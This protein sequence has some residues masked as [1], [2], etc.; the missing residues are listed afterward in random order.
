MDG[1]D[2]LEARN[3]LT[4]AISPCEGR[5]AAEP[6]TDTASDTDSIFSGSESDTSATETG[7]DDS[8]AED[9]RQSIVF[10]AA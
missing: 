6:D 9:L 3:R 2:R 10:H 4:M 8:E 5:Q 7:P 1:R